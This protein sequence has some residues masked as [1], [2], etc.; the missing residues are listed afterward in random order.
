[1]RSESSRAISQAT[2]DMLMIVADILS[3]CEH[4]STKATACERHQPIVTACERAQEA[5]HQVMQE[6]EKLVVSH[7]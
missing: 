6:A 4:C 2:G 1:M 7:E 3:T 5:M